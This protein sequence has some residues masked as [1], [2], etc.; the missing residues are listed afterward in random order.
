MDNEKIIERLRKRDDDALYDLVE[1]YGPILKGVI[2]RTLSKYPHLWD[3]AMN[4]TLLNIWNNIEYFDSSRSSFKNWCAVISKYNSID[5][6]RKESKYKFTNVNE[7]LAD[8]NTDF[9]SKLEIE[10]V[11]SLLDEENKNL[12]KDI[13]LKSLS[14]EEAAKNQGITVNNAYKRV[15]RT[16]KFLRNWYGGM[17]EK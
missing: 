10:E 5:L 16:R 13:F 6:L 7:S 15:S 1:E 11:F 12:F 3:E 9:L 2:S 4:D 8:D 14:Y 17:Y